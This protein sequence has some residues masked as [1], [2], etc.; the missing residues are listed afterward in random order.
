MK[1]VKLT[2]AFGDGPHSL[3]IPSSNI[4]LFEEVTFNDEKG[5]FTKI[6]VK[7]RFGRDIREY[8]IV[9]ESIDEI[10]FQIENYPCKTF[11]LEIQYREILKKGDKILVKQHEREPWRVKLFSHFDGATIL[12]CNGDNIHSCITDKW[13]YW[14]NFVEGMV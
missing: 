8:Y 2:K 11:P 6:F 10:I 14:I 9:K 1:F 12:T 4:L 5:L 3:A 7:E 13:Q